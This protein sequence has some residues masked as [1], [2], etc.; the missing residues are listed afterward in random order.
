MTLPILHEAVCFLGWK[1]QGQLLVPEL[2][3]GTRVRTHKANNTKQAKHAS[4]SEVNGEL[5]DSL[6][7]DRR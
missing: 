5:E 3:P 2:I 7:P 6:T 4:G 1:H